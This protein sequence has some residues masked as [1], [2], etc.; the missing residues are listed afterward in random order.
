MPTANATTTITTHI[1]VT[2]NP[3]LAPSSP[4]LSATDVN[5]AK[6][7]HQQDSASSIILAVTEYPELS[8]LSGPTF[9]DARAAEH[10]KQLSKKASDRAKGQEKECAALGESIWMREEAD[11]LTL[12]GAEGAEGDSDVF[13]VPSRS[14]TYL[15]GPHWQGTDGAAKTKVKPLDLVRPTKRRGGVRGMP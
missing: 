6:L 11:W 5:D 9:K 2:S 13:D 15:S 10:D 14:L 7:S 8:V 12:K 1:A 3:A 4:T